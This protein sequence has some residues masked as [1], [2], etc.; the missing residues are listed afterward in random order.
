MV[1]VVRKLEINGCGL[2]SKKQLEAKII[3]AM[4]NLVKAAQNGTKII[5]HRQERTGRD[6]EELP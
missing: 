1:N 5:E 4:K 3:R 6:N 2:R